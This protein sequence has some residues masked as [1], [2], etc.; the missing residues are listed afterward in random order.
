MRGPLR[1]RRGTWQDRGVVDRVRLLEL[2]GI[3]ELP[4]HQADVSP[5]GETPGGVPA[6]ADVGSDR[7]LRAEL[8]PAGVARRRSPDGH[9]QDASYVRGETPPRL[10]AGEDEL[11]PG[12]QEHDVVC[13]GPGL[14]RRG[15]REGVDDEAVHTRVGETERRADCAERHFVADAASLAVRR[16]DPHAAPA[17]AEIPESEDQ[18][19]TAP[20]VV[21]GGVGGLVADLGSDAVVR[22]YDDKPYEGPDGWSER[23]YNV[24]S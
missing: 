1:E 3:V 7:E 11:Q 13:K 14:P 9:A 17:A 21:V 22:R 18:D 23:T 15:V 16:A 8:V 12:V 10:A 4:E 24:A 2:G 19:A 20:D 6:Q 5:Y